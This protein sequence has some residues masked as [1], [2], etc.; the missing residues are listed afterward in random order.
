MFLIHKYVGTPFRADRHTTYFLGGRSAYLH[1]TSS[2]LVIVPSSLLARIFT[3]F[4]PSV[5]RSVIFQTE[6]GY[7]ELMYLVGVP[8]F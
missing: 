5:S 6:S 4:G 8:E 3:V 1:V 2:D 7:S